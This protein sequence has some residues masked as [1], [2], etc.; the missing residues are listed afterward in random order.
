[1]HAANE[2]V[3]QLLV[4]SIKKKSSIQQFSYIVATYELSIA[5]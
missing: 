3:S 1:M 4:S 5:N 2:L